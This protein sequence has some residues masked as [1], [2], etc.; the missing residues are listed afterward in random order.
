MT[1]KNKTNGGPRKNGKSASGASSSDPKAGR[2]TRN[3]EGQAFGGRADQLGTIVTK[4]L[5]L[6]EAGLSLGL[7][8]INQFGAVA[9]PQRLKDPRRPKSSSTG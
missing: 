7:S 1:E 8:M 2:R 3:T 4:G 6:A 9:Q 5:D